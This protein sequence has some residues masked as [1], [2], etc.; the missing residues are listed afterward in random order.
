MRN[1]AENVEPVCTRTWDL[2][3]CSM[4][5][6]HQRLRWL[7]QVSDYPTAVES[8]S[9]N[10]T[11]I[12]QIYHLG[13]CLG[14]VFFFPKL[15]KQKATQGMFRP[16]FEGRIAR[17]EVEPNTANLQVET[18]V[19]FRWPKNPWGYGTKSFGV[20]WAKIM[21]LSVYIYIYCMYVCMY[22]CR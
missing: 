10:H 9:G 13:I 17:W 4:V 19:M 5:V 8:P 2:C 16:I 20:P 7:Q 21:A 12:S 15:F 6:G 14:L 11:S 22:V 3:A 18:A 1:P